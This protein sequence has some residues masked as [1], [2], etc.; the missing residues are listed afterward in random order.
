MGS[1]SLSG[2]LV[3]VLGKMAALIDHLAGKV[4]HNQEGKHNVLCFT[5][6]LSCDIRINFPKSA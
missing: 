6:D 3:R 5:W 1:R 4:K 2:L